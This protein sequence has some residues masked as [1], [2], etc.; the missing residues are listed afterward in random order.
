MG[1]SLSS[2][3]KKITDVIHGAE[4]Q[5]NPFDNGATYSNPRIGAAPAQPINRQIGN[6]VQQAGNAVNHAYNAPYGVR[7]IVG[8]VNQGFHDT[9][10]QI[11]Q[12]LTRYGAELA[13]TAQQAVTQKPT[14]YHLTPK[15]KLVFGNDPIQSQFEKSRSAYEG[16]KKGKHPELAPLAVVRQA[17]FDLA[18]D[19]PVVAGVAKPVVKAAIDATEAAHLATLKQGGSLETG[20]VGK[21]VNLTPEEKAALPPKQQMALA[22]KE[23]LGPSTHAPAAENLDKNPYKPNVRTVEAGDYGGARVAPQQLSAPIKMVAGRFDYSINKLKKSN[24]DEYNNF[25]KNVE[26][27][28]KNASKDFKEAAYWWREGANRVHGSATTLGP[29]TNYLQDFALH[30]WKLKDV[31]EE[32]L[33]SNG[34]GGLGSH[35]INRVHRDI[36][37]GEAAGLQ[38][39]NNP[40]EEG[41]KYLQG[42]ANAIERLAAKKSLAEAD[43]L[44]ID[45]P[46]TLDLGHGHTVPLSEEGFKQSRALGYHRPSTNVVKRGLRTTNT[47]LKSTLL[48]AGQFHPINI[49]AL[50]AGPALAIKGHPVAAVKG[51]ART[52]R[53][54]LPGGK[55]FVNKILTR[56]YKDG[57]IDKAAE[58][59]MPYGQ[60]GYN[61][62]GTT[63]KSG[64]GHKMVFERQI[65][66][67]HDQ[68]VRSITS[69]LAKKKIPLS[70]PEGRQAGVV[71]DATMGFIDKESL[72]ISPKTRQAMTDF[73]LAGQ[74]TPSKVVTLSKAGK[75]GVAGNYARADVISNAT[76]A[77]ALVS[78]VGYL[79]GQKSDN[80]KDL[81]LRALLNPAIPTPYK[82]KKGNTVEI[83]TPST[84]TAE[85]AKL[86]G[87]GLKR[88]K[89]GHLAVNWTPPTDLQHAPIYE[90]MR[91]RLSPLAGSAIKIATNKNFADKP[92]YDETAPFGKKAIQTGTVLG[93]GSLPIGTQGLLYTD[94]IKK[95]LPGSSQEVLDAGTPGSNPV[96]KSG[97]SS[98]GFTPRTDQTVGKAKDTAAYFAT[99]KDALS[100]AKNISE[101]TALENY[102][103]SKK[104]SVT[105]K[106]NVSPNPNDSAR[107]AKDLLDAPRT[108]D[109][110]RSANQKLQK[111]GGK[112]DPLWNLSKDQITKV[113]QY[114]TMA[115]GG[116]DR[117]HW[118]N[119]NKDWYQPAS[120]A[121]SAFFNSLPKG[122]PNK[123]QQPIEYPAPS[124]D[125]NAKLNA[126]KGIKD[127]AKYSQFLQDNPDVQDQFDKAAAYDNKMRVATLG[128]GSELDTYPTA[129]PQ[130]K[131]LMDV[132]NA[133]PQHDGPK[134]GSKTRSLW[135]Q[136]HP[137]EFKTLT[138]AW[139]E[140]SLYGLEKSAAQAEFKDTGFD[141]KGLKDIASVAKDIG[142]TTDSNGNTFYAL[143]DGSGS[144]GGSSYTKYASSSK[145][146]RKSS[147]SSRSS[148]VPN[149]GSEY[150]YAVSLNAGGKPKRPKVTVRGGAKAKNK[151]SISKP[152]VTS[153]KS[154]V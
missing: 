69:D 133:L 64:V 27:T 107:K 147:G 140:R 116:P 91:S 46:R 132:Y 66:M 47:A 35:S 55:G 148:K 6:Y 123:P 60:S 77:F 52:F 65:P 103:G 62:A 68:V 37:S 57:M 9:E 23:G 152:K 88:G 70:S 13:A 5:I 154:L 95:H 10:R 109:I 51:I 67:M 125:V 58:L 71:G 12:S 89:D 128:K 130:V 84:Y 72:N 100:Q 18:N 4:R 41:L 73:M 1:L 81:A 144:S 54:L 50:R 26:N 29:N 111:S 38:L 80:A 7:N 79:A 93:Q 104:N 150:K 59:G 30:P 76:A 63:L 40:H 120:D 137:N 36:S 53:P 113:L 141:Q 99:A 97:L 87:L 136:A 151:V 94:S 105:G 110:I 134:G 115:Y 43:A 143:G 56:A 3:G 98:V 31:T 145:S 92:L 108:I 19:V 2:L 122:D 106:Y 139:T 44:A 121:R 34:M 153:K 74:F 20:A 146:S 75:G 82:D 16:A 114:Q 25:W 22:Q 39:G 86:L 96:L 24:P 90:W 138:Q 129:S 142:T 135:I 61:T 112:I 83:R 117:A 21:N 101:K 131:K 126:L 32:E 17:G 48:S 78:G 102:Y 8:G 124:N 15:E 149:A 127:P 49:S 33:A 45:K 28:P 11:G 119:Q 14:T 118:Y 42:G 85:I